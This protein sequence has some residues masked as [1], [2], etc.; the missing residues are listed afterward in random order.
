MRLVYFTAQNFDRGTIKI[1]LAVRG[2]PIENLNRGSP[3]KFDTRGMNRMAAARAALKI[4]C[5]ESQGRIV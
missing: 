4:V 2:R 5:R 3:S 1:L